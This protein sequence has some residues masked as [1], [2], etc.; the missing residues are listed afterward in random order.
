MLKE[1]NK[2]MENKDFPYEREEDKNVPE[3][4]MERR[5]VLTLK[6]VNKLKTLR[7]KKREELA[8]DSI[9]VP[10][11]YGPKEEQPGGMGGLGF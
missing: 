5:K 8:Q 9:F 6:L 4:G 1:L 11:L 10:Y 7:N 3:V 2:L